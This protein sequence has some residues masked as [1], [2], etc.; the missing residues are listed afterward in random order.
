[1][2]NALRPPLAKRERSPL[3]FGSY[4]LRPN[5]LMDKDGS[6]T[7]VGLS[8]KDFV[9]DADPALSGKKDGGRVANF[10]PI[11]IAAKRLDESGWHLAWR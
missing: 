3:N 5:G 1:M 6:W 10:Q 11:S 4:L 2:A 7:E 8:P 9:L